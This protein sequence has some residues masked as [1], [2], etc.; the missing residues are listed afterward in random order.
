MR[1]SDTKHNFVILLHHL[2][3]NQQVVLNPLTSG[4]QIQAS[5]KSCSLN[6]LQVL[7]DN[8]RECKKTPW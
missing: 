7:A 2:R 3:G 5:V 8:I 6:A 1:T 4:C